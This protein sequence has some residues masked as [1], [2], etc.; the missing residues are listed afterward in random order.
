MPTDDHGGR[1][2]RAY[3]RAANTHRRA[4]ATELAASEFF[5]AHG[6]DAAAERHRRNA[7][8]QRDR[9]DADDAR[10]ETAA[11]DSD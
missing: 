11:Q 6:D 9:A 7:A 2:E 4:E 1:R 10:A 8:L 5:A 3:R